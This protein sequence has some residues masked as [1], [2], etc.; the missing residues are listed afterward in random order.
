MGTRRHR[1]WR[2]RA[3][4]GQQVRSKGRRR[5]HP[6]SGTTAGRRRN[7]RI[8][9]VVAPCRKH[10]LR[11]VFAPRRALRL[12]RSPGKCSQHARVQ[13]VEATGT[14]LEQRDQHAVRRGA[15]R[16]LHRRTGWNPARDQVGCVG[17]LDAVDRIEHG[18]VQN[19]ERS[20]GFGWRGPAGS[21]GL[22]RRR[23]PVCDDIGKP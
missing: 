10:L 6:D 3:P 16:R 14:L 15:R 7:H 8:R 2:H 22:P 18:Q 12:V 23:V 17:P 4:L 20:R 5:W 21:D 19:R 9:I 13:I 11:D 1:E